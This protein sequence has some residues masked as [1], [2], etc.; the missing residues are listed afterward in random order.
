MFKTLSLLSRLSLLL[1]AVLALGL[2]LGVALLVRHAG[3]RIRVEAEAAQRLAQ[4][5]VE[6]AL[7]RAEAAADPRTELA[8]LL[9]QAQKL[10]HVRIFVEGS[11]AT[12]A[13]GPRA[14]AWFEELATPRENIARIALDPP[15]HGA[16]VVAANPA[17]E[18][19][20][21][22]EE[23]VELAV[24]GALVALAAFALLFIAVS[25]TLA[26]VSSLVAGLSRLEQGEHETRVAASGSPEFVV[27]AERI[28]ALAAALERLDAENRNLLARS[29]ET[30]EKE[31]RE[32]AQD[33]HD[34]IGPF[35]FAIRAGVG[36]LRRK[37]GNAAFEG[38][39]AKIDAQVAALQR[40]NRRILARLRPAAL[41]EMG[42]AGALEAM[43]SG[44]R[45]TH[46][47]PAISIGVDDLRLSENLALV[48]YRIVQEGLT[49]AL[50]HSGAEH[51][52]IRVSSPSPGVL[53]VR[54]EDDGRGFAKG[55]RQGLG[56]R[57]MGERIV[58]L[59]GRLTLANASPKGA[60]LEARLPFEASHPPQ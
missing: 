32:I 43:A 48:A 37:Q 31:R 58:A 25:R 36:A 12:A 56:L 6:S 18:I 8:R 42:L 3:G 41:E 50:R 44:W 54:V 7:P 29:M 34:E 16:L 28:N 39:C 46:P 47:G 21:I 26:P 38:D 22:W 5:F 49:N 24:V 30:Q 51:V 19:A 2:A 55:W 4:D 14:P 59:G 33:L 27:I 35:L 40:V 20:E 13:A 52:A 17:D 60:V 53:F 1:G 57:G 45:E 9:E 11:G 15:L 23:I 10:R